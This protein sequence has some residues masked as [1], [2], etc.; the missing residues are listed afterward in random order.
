MEISNFLQYKR[1]LL[2]F[3]KVSRTTF[4]THKV[5]D[6]TCNEKDSAKLNIY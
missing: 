3:Y 5:A 2:F 4:A 6:F 1:A